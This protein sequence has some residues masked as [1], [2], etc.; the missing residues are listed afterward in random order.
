MLSYSSLIRPSPNDGNLRTHGDPL[1]M[2]REGGYDSNRY[3]YTKGNAKIHLN[4][5]TSDAF[6][7]ILGTHKNAVTN[8]GGIV[9]FPAK[10]QTQTIGNEY[11]NNPVPIRNALIQAPVY[12]IINGLVDKP[13]P[14]DIN[15]IAKA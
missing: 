15:P 7:H 10:Q 12:H 5:R 4:N 8:Y 3:L 2:L 14:V 9:P 13:L 11:T 6:N 1:G